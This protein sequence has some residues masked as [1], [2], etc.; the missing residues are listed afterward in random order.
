MTIAK[1]ELLEHYRKMRAEMDDALEGLSDE[2]LSDP[3]LDGWAVK[4]H[5]AHIAA[6]EASL[7]GLLEGADRATAMGL[8]A[9]GDEETDELNDEI[10]HLHRDKSPQE[11]LAYFRAR[12]PRA[13]RD[14]DEALAFVIAHADSRAVQEACV[15]ALVRKTEILWHLLDCV[16]HAREGEVKTGEEKA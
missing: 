12:V 16:D 5:L 15:E 7:I 1:E 8:A 9:N 11:A 3:S 13:R 14:G 10:W 4:D 2:D 6:W